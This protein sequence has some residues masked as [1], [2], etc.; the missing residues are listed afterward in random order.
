M[1]DKKI[2]KVWEEI[3]DK[4]DRQIAQIMEELDKTIAGLSEQ[5]G[6]NKARD[7]VK[8]FEKRRTE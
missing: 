7:A 1:A 3:G 8:A 5:E 6:L 2:W 4:Q